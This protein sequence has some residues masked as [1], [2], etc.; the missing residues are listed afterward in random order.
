[1]G[2]ESE[3]RLISFMMAVKDGESNIEI[4]RQRLCSNRDF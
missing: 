3:R 2:Y 4:A 1:L